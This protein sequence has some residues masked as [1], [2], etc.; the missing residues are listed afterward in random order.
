MKVLVVGT[1]T[2]VGKTHVACA[3]LAYLKGAHIPAIGWKPIASGGI[4]DARAHADAGSEFVEPLYAFERPVSP[5]LGAREKGVTIDFDRIRARA[6]ELERRGGILIV[7]TVGGMFSP[8]V[9]ELCQAVF[10]AA[11]VLVAPDRLGVLH[12]VSACVRA[13]AL[14]ILGVAMSAPKEPDASTGTNAAEIETLK[15]SRTLAL[16]PREPW[17]SPASLDAAERV[18][19][20]VSSS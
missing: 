6:D 9:P 13:S 16:F 17:E 18:W 4:D 14:P 11:I 19:R 7:E 3:L 10:P 12:D 1:G 15:I 2:D 8:L 20:T 5:H